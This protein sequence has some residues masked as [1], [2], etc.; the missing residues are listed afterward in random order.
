VQELNTEN[1]KVQTENNELNLEVGSLKSDIEILRS[2]VEE[3][4]QML[5]SNQGSSAIDDHKSTIVNLQSVR[6]DQNIPN[7]F[8]QSTTINY[9]VPGNSGTTQ[10]Q[11]TSSFG[12]VIKTIPVKTEGHGQ[13]MLKAGDLSSGIY[14]YQLVVNGQVIATKKLIVTK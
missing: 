8:D 10:I 12:E 3:M 6:L 9:F 2:E 13:L 4:K 5:V 7:P 1:I 14:N 11:I